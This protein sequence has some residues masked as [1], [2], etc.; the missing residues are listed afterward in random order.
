MVVKNELVYEVIMTQTGGCAPASCS[1]TLSGH[2]YFIVHSLSLHEERIK[3]KR[4]SRALC[5]ANEGKS[6]KAEHTPPPV[7][8]LQEILYGTV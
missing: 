7:L 2:G 6:S 4:S 8:L 5:T 3:E 1:H